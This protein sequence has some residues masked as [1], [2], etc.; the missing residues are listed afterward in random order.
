MGNVVVFQVSLEIEINAY[1]YAVDK[2]KYLM[3]EIVNALQ[4]FQ[5]EPKINLAY[6][7]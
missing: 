2:I 6:L 5:E 3:V 7:K 4:D 1:Q